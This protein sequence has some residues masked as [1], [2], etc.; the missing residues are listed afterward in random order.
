MKAHIADLQAIV[1]HP[2]PPTFENVIQAYDQ[3][4]HLFGRVASVFSN[5]CSS[6]NTEDLQAVQTHM[7][8]ILSRHRSQTYTLPRL[9]HKIDQVYQQQQ[10]QQGNHPLSPEQRRLVQRVYMD[11]TRQGAH[12]DEPTQKEYADLKAQL[13]S[14]M[15]QFM[16]NIMK[17]ESTYELVVSLDDLRG[18]PESLIQAARQAAQERNKPDGDYVITLS[19]SLVEPFLIFCESR[20]LR[21]TAWEAWTTRGQLDPNRQNIPL[22]EEILRLRHRQAQLHGYKTFAEYQCVDRMAKTP[23]NV[24]ALLENV[25]QRAKVS[26]NRERQALEEYVRELELD[27]GADDGIQP[28]DWRY[29]AEK[30]RRAKYDFDQTLLKPYL[31]L[32]SVR[33]AMFAVSGHL[34]GLRYLPREDIRSYHPDVNT[35]QVV[36]QQDPDKTVAI[37]LHDNYSRKFKGGGAW[38]SEYRSQTKNLPPGVD[39]VETIPIVTN[40]NNLAKGSSST[41]LSY[42]GMS[43]LLNS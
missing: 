24:M 28:W 7:S 4:G 40:N 5:L 12:F 25:W 16:Q 1:D 19:R 23:E 42:D 27:L 43:I 30:V 13:A 35:Y 33:E 11:F 9:F 17:D 37:F 31:S 34:F 21:Q 39:P 18:C 32:E 20:T 36:S 6:V 10:T 38:M 26:A 3:A 29:V 15:T 41:L 14:L 2:E 22:A 8:P